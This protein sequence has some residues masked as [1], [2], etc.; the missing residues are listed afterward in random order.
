MFRNLLSFRRA[1]QCS[2]SRTR[3]Q[4][5]RP[6]LEAL[7]DRLV[8]STFHWAAD[9]DGSFNDATKWL[10][11]NNRHRV[12][13]PYDD[14]NIGYGDITVTS[15]GNAIHKLT[16]SARL[17]VLKGT[18]SITGNSSSIANLDLQAGATLKVA[19]GVTMSLSDGTDVE[20]TITLLGTS[21][22]DFY[23]NDVIGAVINNPAN[24]RIKF[25]N[26]SF[27]GSTYNVNPGAALNGPGH[28]FIGST[29][30]VTW[31]QNTDLTVQNL[32]LD[33]GSDL[34]STT[35]DLTV[36]GTLNW[37]DGTISGS[38]SLTIVQGAT[39][40]VQAVVGLKGYTI[41][42]HGTANW[43]GKGSITGVN[44]QGVF[45]N[46]TDGI[47]NVQDDTT[48]WDGGIFL[49]NGVL[50]KSSLVQG[51][52]NFGFAAF[53]NAGT[54]NV[55]SGA[56][57]AYDGGLQSGAFH[58]AGA[59]TLIFDGGQTWAAGVSFAGASA[60][61]VGTFHVGDGGGGGGTVTVATNVTLPNL[62]ID[63]SDTVSVNTGVTLTVSGLLSLGS[64]TNPYAGNLAGGGNL[65]LPA[66]AFFDWHFGNN[67]I[68]GTTTIEAKATLQLESPQ[69]AGLSNGTLDNK[70][71]I[72]WSGP[73]N[74][75]VGNAQIHNEVG[76]TFND[77]NDHSIGYYHFTFTN[78]GVYNK[79]S[80]VGTGGTIFDD[81]I[82]FNSTGTVNVQS[83]TLDIPGGTSSGTFNLSS[84]NSVVEFI[85]QN[86][87]YV[88]NTGAQFQG[89]GSV[90]L[91]YHAMYINGN[92]KASN[93]SLDNQGDL[94][95]P[96][97][98]TVSGVFTWTGGTIADSAGTLTV[99]KTG[100][101]DLK[102]NSGKELS[103]RTVYLYGA[104]LWQDSGGLGV[105]SDATIYNE[106][107]AT[108]TI[109]NDQTLSSGW[110]RGHIYNFGTVAKTG[111]TG[112]TSIAGIFSNSGSVLVTAG[113]L[114]FTGWLA[115]I[116]PSG[117]T[118]TGGTWSVLGGTSALTFTNYGNLKTLGALASVTL[119]GA[120]ASFTNLAG[121]TSNLGTLSLL[122]GQTFMTTGDFNNNGTLT[123]GPG[124]TLAVSG[125]YVQTVTG[126]LNVQIGGT[127]TSPTAGTITTSSTGTVTLGGSL[128]VTATVKPAVGMAFKIVNN[129][130]SAAVHGIFAGLA[131]GASITVNGMTF[132]IS[133]RGGD[134]NDVVLTRTA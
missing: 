64:P 60:T 2:P 3:R 25:L 117:T 41:H 124:S 102:G 29:F 95:G 40:N 31:T 52:S 66:G 91:A 49:N 44:A 39:L 13:G 14:A 47:A 108:F 120:G 86:S 37:E 15:T 130:G 45:I 5:F 75:E 131:E 42:N 32:E 80:P 122:G 1:P 128:N 100:T 88:L 83:G 11:Q 20:G 12:P 104:T 92:V 24:S 16:S 9:V 133:Y 50:N 119:S 111:I 58:V 78:D 18:L 53:N 93:F 67:D 68:A 112:T 76:G 23:G 30:G 56:L 110:N 27:W 123:L 81:R 17:S 21:E 61:D 90:Y 57:E 28:Y 46:E 51:T 79:S 129:K 84:P 113:T 69:G 22:L 48:V 107:G 98:L 89:A 105:D 8:P 97:N 87:A 125:S 33:I 19:N 38:R 77:Q 73:G 6:R 59:G 132:K 116:D 36:T 109:A 134:G 35:N 72:N 85:G 54:V 34:T 43:T 65:D 114:S 101:L 70:G 7:E 74:L 71:T 94:D 121:L 103:G 62:T 106:A 96:G 126:T 118:L 4:N 55:H 127:A 82:A 26:S 115:Q 99:A 63:T 10:D